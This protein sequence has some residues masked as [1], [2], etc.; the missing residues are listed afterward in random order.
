[1]KRPVY[2]G[3]FLSPA[4][5]AKLLRDFPPMYE[6]VFAD[7]VTLVFG[8]KAS[9]LGNYPF[10]SIVRLKAVGYAQDQKGTA[11]LVDLPPE[12]KKLTK[13]TPHI[14]ISTASGVPPVYSNQL[15][16]KPANITRVSPKIYEGTLDGFPRNRLASA[17]VVA[18]NWLRSKVADFAR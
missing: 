1:M 5:R 15:I 2:I 4:E 13:K 10:G 11:L 3:I 7:H 17:E 12:I 9:D 16:S 14:T 18:D 8:P 6:N